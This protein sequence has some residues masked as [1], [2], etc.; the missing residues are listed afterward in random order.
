MEK[1]V[2]KS[3]PAHQLVRRTVALVLAVVRGSSS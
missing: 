2:E 1:S 3:L